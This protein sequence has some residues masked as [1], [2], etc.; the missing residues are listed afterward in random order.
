MKLTLYCSRE[1]WSLPHGMFCG[2]PPA[3]TCSAVVVRSSSSSSNLCEHCVLSTH[4]VGRGAFS[5]GDRCHTQCLSSE[6]LVAAKWGRFGAIMLL[7]KG[8]STCLQVHSLVHQL[9]LIC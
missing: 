3:A 7:Y 8:G 4:E 5:K 1:T 2:S 9:S 6:A